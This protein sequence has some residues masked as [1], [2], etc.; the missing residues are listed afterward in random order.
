[1]KIIFTAIFALA[2][3][4]LLNAQHIFSVSQ[5]SLPEKTVFELKTQIK[6]TEISAL[7][8]SKN[9]E[10]LDIYCVAFLQPDNTKI[11]IFNEETGNNVLITPN[12]AALHKT[13]H[14]SSLQLTSF[15]IE[16]LK[17]GVLGNAEHY[18]VIETDTEFSVKNVVSVYVSNEEVILPRFFYG[19]KDNK[20]E[21]L[22]QNRQIINIYR[23]KPRLISA[24]PD[25]VETQR[26][27][28][29]LEDEMSYY[30]YMYKLPDGSLTTYR[31]TLK[32]DNEKVTRVG[33]NLEFDL[34]GSLNAQQ[35]A[36]TEYVLDLWGSKLAGVVPV[37]INVDFI[38]LPTN[39]IGATFFTPN[40]FNP[41]NDSWYWSSL[42]NQLVGYDATSMK[43][44]DIAM[45]S[46]FNFYFGF[47]CNSSLPDYVTLMLHE[48]THGLGFGSSIKSDGSYF[49][50]NSNNIIQP[51]DF[52]SIYDRMLYQGLDGVCITELSQEERAALIISNNLYAAGPNLLEANEGVRVKIYAPRNYQNGSSTHHWDES[53]NNFTTFMYPYYQRPLHTFNTRK[54]G[55]LC[56]MGWEAAQIPTFWVRYNANGGGANMAPQS[57]APDEEQNLRENSFT[58]SGYAFKNWNTSPDGSGTTYE[59]K[60]A[61][62]LSADLELFA[63]WD[64]ANYT[65][66][67]FANGGIVN[68]TSKQVTYQSPIGELPIPEREGYDFQE[69]RI[70][71]IRINEETV[72]NYTASMTATARWV[73]SSGID[74]NQFFAGLQ[75]IPNPTDG[76]LRIM[77]YEL[78]ITNERTLSEGVTERSRSIEIF[79]V[80]GRNVLTSS[81]SLLS[82]ETMLDI[83]YLPSGVYFLRVGNEMVKPK[84][85]IRNN[86]SLQNTIIQSLRLV[87]F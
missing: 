53:V 69:W 74:D 49:Y 26:Q 71:A 2:A 66:T 20:Q 43:D 75:I 37:E 44:I 76:Q 40:F 15:F 32:S 84:F 16:E 60:E 65:L 3:A 7:Q 34:T 41:V 86:T 79:D 82:P 27:I 80:A 62:T 83:S 63:Q 17:Q 46:N 13:R 5:N 61:V 57:F 85:R 55:I 72:W 51:T 35:R 9:N 87:F 18:L 22:P 77:N 81:L 23:Q 10:N 52:P 1:M 12:V 39:V 78:R 25:N 31:H 14:A 48:V 50:Y 38:P 30:V 4:G 68:P 42:W 19:K 58:Y 45:S 28:A 29:Q 24:F 67:F 54:I 8:L 59:D 36:A 6:K 70:G 64:F 56:D 21:A 33:K 73:P 11:I 47:D